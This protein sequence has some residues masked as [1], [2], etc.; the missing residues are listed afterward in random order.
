[1]QVRPD[2]ASV[3]P[4]PAWFVHDVVALVDTVDPVNG[5][6]VDARVGP[7]RQPRGSAGDPPT[8]VTREVARPPEPGRLGRGDPGDRGPRS[9]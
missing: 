2:L 6:E 4:A 7:V 9:E 3:W 8:R 1:V 5:V